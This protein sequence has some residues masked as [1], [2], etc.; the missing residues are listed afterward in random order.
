MTSRAG[1]SFAAFP[2]IDVSA[3]SALAPGE[4]GSVAPASPIL[5]CRGCGLSKGELQ[6]GVAYQNSSSRRR[7]SA[8]RPRDRRI[9]RRGTLGDFTRVGAPRAVRYRARG[10]HGGENRIRWAP[11]APPSASSLVIYP[12]KT[13]DQ[14]Q[15]SQARIDLFVG[16]RATTIFFSIQPPRHTPDAQRSGE[17][18]HARVG[19]EHTRRAQR[20]KVDST[21]HE[22]REVAREARLP[23]LEGEESGHQATSGVSK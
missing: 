4:T 22:P 5:P 10:R 23:E 16:S 21:F 15:P 9:A 6:P 17:T 11:R 13:T 19:F 3:V 18:Q 12:W 2:S 8:S 1:S 14:S 7:A 20:R